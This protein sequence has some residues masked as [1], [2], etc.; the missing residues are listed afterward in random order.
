MDQ[1][2]SLDTEAP[3]EERLQQEESLRGMLTPRETEVLTL[4]ARGYTNLQM[5]H[6]LRLSVSTVKKHL[7]GPSRSLAYRIAPRRPFGCRAGC[8]DRA[9]GSNPAR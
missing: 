3:K 6:A 1:K 7:R 5:A 4:T 9:E 2:P 8:A